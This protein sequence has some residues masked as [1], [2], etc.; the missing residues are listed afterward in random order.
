VVSGNTGA[1]ALMIG[2]K[3]SDMILGRTS[4]AESLAADRL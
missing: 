1:T 4:R 3:G 2:A